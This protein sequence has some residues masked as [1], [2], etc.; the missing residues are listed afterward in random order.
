MQDS[1][2]RF[3]PDDL[4][5]VEADLQQVIAQ[6]S[7]GSS[8]Y[9]IVLPD[10]AIRIV[11]AV[12]RAILDEAGKVTRL[13]G[14]N[15]DITDR[16]AAEDE[17]FA[18]KER[19]QVTLSSIGDAVV[20][21]DLAGNISFINP[22]AEEMTGWSKNEATGRPM[23]EILRIQHD[24]SREVIPNPMELAM[25]ENQTMNLPSS[26]HLVRRDGKETPIEDSVSPIHDSRWTSHRRRHCLP[27]CHH[28]SGN[29]TEIGVFGSARFPHW[30]AQSNSPQRP[31][32]PGDRGI[33]ATSNR[34]L[35]GAVSRSRRIQ[36]TSTILSDIRS[37]TGCSNPSPRASGIASAALIP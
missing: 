34:R 1:P 2:Q 22:V 7:Q 28:G 36:S 19:A 26:C 11:F 25:V 31:R 23:A 24:A 10:G 17:L 16:R 18:E 33:V 35:H 30:S 8:E 37:A 27:G 15:T 21:T 29:G 20:S 9:R 3:T 6:N 12:Q 32:K 5:K 14:V 13:V 4:A